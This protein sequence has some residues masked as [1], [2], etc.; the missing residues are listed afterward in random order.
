MKKV[1]EV[2]FAARINKEIADGVDREAAAR[3]V[4][5][6]VVIREALEKYLKDK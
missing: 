1:K 6:S 3:N 2:T 5:R 4:K